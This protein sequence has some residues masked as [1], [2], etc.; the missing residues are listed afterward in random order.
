MTL[1]SVHKLPDIGAASAFMDEK[2][3]F[4]RYIHPGQY[5]Y[6]EKHK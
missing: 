2:A 1:R 4:F 6:K 5:A 3:L